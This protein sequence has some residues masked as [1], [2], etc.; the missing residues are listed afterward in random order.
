M[1]NLM[2]ITMIVLMIKN[3]YNIKIKIQK[4]NIR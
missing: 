1:I 3:K 4:T 2:I